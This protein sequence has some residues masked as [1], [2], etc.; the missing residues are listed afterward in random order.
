[1]SEISVEQVEWSWSGLCAALGVPEDSTAE[2]LDDLF[3]SS[4]LY[5]A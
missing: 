5:D 4:D 3:D 2:T 1:M